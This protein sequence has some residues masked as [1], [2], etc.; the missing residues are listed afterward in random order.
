[1]KTSA[2]IMREMMDDYGMG[3]QQIADLLGISL[4]SAFRVANRQVDTRESIYIKLIEERSKLP[5]KKK[6][7]K[8]A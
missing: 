8:V 6:A 1:M 3:Y 4:S 5:R 2:E 7:R